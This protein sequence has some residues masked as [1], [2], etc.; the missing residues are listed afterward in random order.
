MPYPPRTGSLQCVFV[1]QGIDRTRTLRGAVCGAVAAAV[2]GLQQ[3]LDKLAFSSRYDD[4]ELLGKAVTRGDAWYPVGLAVH[5]GNGA[6]FGA[7]YANVAPTVPIP[8]RCA[9][10]L[11]GCWSTWRSGHWA[12]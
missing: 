12:R 10:P 11:R 2:W 8:P 9:D 1:S 4:I 5:L 3:P 6:L 7:L